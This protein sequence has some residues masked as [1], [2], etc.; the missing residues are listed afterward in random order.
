V[1]SP[2]HEVLEGP[3]RATISRDVRE[4]V[5]LRLVFRPEFEGASRRVKWIAIDP[6]RPE[7]GFAAPAVASMTPARRWCSSSIAIAH[8][9][10]LRAAAT[11]GSEGGA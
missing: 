7:T 5:G 10:R 8:L 9:G 2:C 3:L 11:V 1:A 4:L 6:W